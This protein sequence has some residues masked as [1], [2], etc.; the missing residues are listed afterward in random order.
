VVVAGILAAAVIEDLREEKPVPTL[1]VFSDWF[2]G[3][4]AL[5][6]AEDRPIVEHDCSKPIPLTG[7]LKCR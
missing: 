5:P 7:N 1:E 3:T 2:W 4:P 6:L